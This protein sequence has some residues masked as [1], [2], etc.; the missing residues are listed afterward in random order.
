MRQALR[1][2]S[3]QVEAS[4]PTTL[5]GSTAVVGHNSFTQPRLNIS[6]RRSASHA[7]TRL[8]AA[9][10]HHPVVIAVVAGRGRLADPCGLHVLVA[11]RQSPLYAQELLDD[12]IRRGTQIEH[13]PTYLSW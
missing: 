6:H 4:T 7:R 10:E 11:E 8:P 13:S 1:V 3:P 2:S 9:A 5:P 12:R